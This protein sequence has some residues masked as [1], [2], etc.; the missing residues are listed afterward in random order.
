MKRDDL[1]L[2]LRFS[3]IPFDNWNSP[4][5]V[6]A[7]NF[8]PFQFKTENSST[9][10]V[11]C[12]VVN[13]SASHTIV[14]PD[15]KIFQIG[16]YT[17]YIFEGTMSLD[18]GKYYLQI[19]DGEFIYYSVVFEVCDLEPLGNESCRRDDIFLPLRFREGIWNTIPI[20]A[21]NNHL[22]PFQFRTLNNSTGTVTSYLVDRA[23][24]EILIDLDITIY[25]VNKW[26]YYLWSGTVDEVETGVYYLKL[27]DGAYEYYSVPF[28][29]CDL[30]SDLEEGVY[31]YLYKFPVSD[32]YG[33][34]YNWYAVNTGMLA[35]A[36]WRVSSFA[37]WEDLATAV[38]SPV[39]GNLK[40]TGYT[41]WDSPNTGAMNIVNFNARGGGIR[42]HS[43]G[44]T[45]IN[46]SA[47]FWKTDDDI[48]DGYGGG[49]NYASVAQI[50]Y[51]D[52]GISSGEANF[53]NK[54]QGL[55]V[56]LVRDATEAEQLLDDGTACDDYVGNDGKIYPTVKIGTQV[57]TAA[58]LA[59]TKYN[60]DSD[61]P[62]VTDN[63]A[64]AALVTG[65]M[66]YYNNETRKE[67]APIGWHVPTVQDTIDLAEAIDT[68]Y[69]YTAGHGG[70]NVAGKEMKESGTEY[71]D[72]DAG[73]N[74]SGFN[75]RGAGWR[76]PDGTFG[77]L[78][79]SLIIWTDKS[80][81]AG[82]AYFAG[83]Y[84]SEDWFNVG[85]YKVDKNYGHSIRLVKDSTDKA[86]GEEGTMTGNDGKEYRTKVIGGK[87]WMMQ[88][89][90][91]TKYRDGTDIPKI[92]DA[93]AWAA[94][95]EG[96]CAYDNDENNV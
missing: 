71:W 94:A 21:D 27:V 82:D 38:G 76:E 47:L 86:E 46:Q 81:L 53:S 88:N 29:V 79:S 26:T 66:C 50:V 74:S 87:E 84:H 16:D 37:D 9:G 57:W 58:N 33:A 77:E 69:T 5:M 61:I 8:I 32:P 42:E 60:D 43:G 45:E 64:W 73:T 18:P 15:I 80:N 89:L 49:A 65:A 56:R 30:E 24:N 17:Y 12:E 92:T 3:D 14:T 41:Y 13:F 70:D 55:S 6:D 59:E 78:K 31:G 63:A 22:L 83:L 44:Y 20:I 4:I 75:G 7:A 48:D 68:A 67:I 90:A 19:T 1:W 40:E 10:S 96:Y 23:G 2:P 93:V 34:L 11:T 28:E 52:S 62:V 91:E 36:G 72:T 85:D 35:A 39:G 25:Q 54:K 51:D 95:T